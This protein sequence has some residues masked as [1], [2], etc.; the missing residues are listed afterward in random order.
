MDV[1]A[2]LSTIITV[3]NTLAKL[4]P[5]FVSTWENL[6]P[7]ATTLYQEFT[8]QDISDEDLLKLEAALDDLHAKFQEP[9][10]E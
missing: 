6:K 9:L 3:I 7:Y 10:P 1:T 5:T 8:G 4:E 2:A